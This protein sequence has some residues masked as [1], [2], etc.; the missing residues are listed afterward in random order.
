MAARDVTLVDYSLSTEEK[1]SRV[2][3]TRRLHLRFISCE[4]NSSRVT[5]GQSELK[6]FM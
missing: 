3:E 5:S 1:M 2:E 4:I 6:A